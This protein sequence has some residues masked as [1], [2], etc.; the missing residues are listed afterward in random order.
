M[1]STLSAQ[2]RTSEKYIK[3]NTALSAA[4]II[5]LGLVSWFAKE[6]YA[7]VTTRLQALEVSRIQ[8]SLDQVK[9]KTDESNHW[10]A[11][12]KGLS[13]IDQTLT[14]INARID[15]IHDRH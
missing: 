10:D 13:K 12:E 2:R 1:T 3:L 15:N 9:D 11:T 5:L 6:K 14:I 8:L 4:C 7:D